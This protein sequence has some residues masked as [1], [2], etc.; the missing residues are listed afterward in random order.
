MSQ[1][2]SK[3]VSHD[4]SWLSRRG[5]RQEPRTWISLWFGLSTLLVLWGERSA[6]VVRAWI[7]NTDC[8]EFPSDA[9]YCLLRPRSMLGG[10]LHWL[11][12]PYQ[13]VVIACLLLASQ[14][15]LEE[16]N[17]SSDYTER[18]TT[19]TVSR[20]YITI[21][22]SLQLRL[23]S[24]WSNPSS[25]SSTCTWL[26][27]GENRLK[28][29]TEWTHWR[30]SSVLQEQSWHWARLFYIGCK[31]RCVTRRH[32]YSRCW[33][34]IYSDIQNTTRGMVISATITYTIS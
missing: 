15:E 25:I 8:L 23:L 22:V 14:A 28:G 33:I 5:E 16:T 30:L 7:Y 34:V 17:T 20:L 18:S 2:I 26:I 13:S 9:G 10:D 19:F 27:L 4:E 29:R 24:T 11:W 21:P 1:L 32:P 12:K 31:V 3:P 6:Q